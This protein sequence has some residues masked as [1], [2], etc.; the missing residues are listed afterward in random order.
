MQIKLRTLS[1]L[2]FLAFACA[3]SYAQELGENQYEGYVLDDKGKKKEGILQVARSSSPWENQRH[4]WF[5]SKKAWEKSGGKVKKKDKEKFKAKDIQGY[6]FDGREFRQVKYVSSGNNDIGSEV[7]K[8][9]GATSAI[10]NLTKNKHL[11]EVVLD[12]EVKMYR[13]YDY[14]P[15]V[16]ATVGG[17]EA[18]KMKEMQ[19][20][21]RK[22]YSILIKKGK[23]GK[24]RD[25]SSILSFKKF[26]ADCKPVSKKYLND[27]YTMKSKG[28]KGMV[29]KSMGSAPLEKMLVEIFTDYNA[30]CGK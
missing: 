9:S 24:L 18:E 10:G 30:E 1:L 11:L 3:G 25:F 14:P 27:E 6:G 7:N 5:I 19:E 29:Q 16:S 17:E 20:D 28:V 22:N 13:Y 23:K 26:I 12:G 8:F 15:E 2:A 4:V 21:L